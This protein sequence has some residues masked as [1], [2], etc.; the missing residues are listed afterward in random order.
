MH[1][2]SSYSSSKTLRTDSLLK[3]GNSCQFHNQ[4]FIEIAVLFTCASFWAL[5]HNGLHE[6]N[7]WRSA[8]WLCYSDEPPR[9]LQSL[10][11]EWTT[12]VCAIFIY[13]FIS[14]QRYVLISHI[15]QSLM[16][17]FRN[18]QWWKPQDFISYR[19]R[20]FIHVPKY[21]AP[22]WF[23]NSLILCICMCNIIQVMCLHWGNCTSAVTPI[24]K[25]TAKDGF[26][27]TEHQSSRMSMY[28]TASSWV[29]KHA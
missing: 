13:L 10:G 4:V 7:E 18:S 23:P 17:H 26:R 25:E 29:S 16:Q 3:T 24:R 15:Y 8:H 28:W 27:C 14:R 1:D 20:C 5:K 21:H 2:F 11:F 19:S 22:F 6:T 9:C 12:K